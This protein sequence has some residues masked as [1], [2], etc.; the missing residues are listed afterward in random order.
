MLIPNWMSDATYVD[1]EIHNG[2]QTYKWEKTGNQANYLYETTETSPTNRTTI[3]VY[4]EPSD[5]QDFGSKSTVF[6]SGTFTLPSV[7]TVKNPTTWG[8]CKD[9]RDT[10]K[11]IRAEEA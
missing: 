7:C 9:I 6:P 11:K 5:F 4:Q 3:S 10:F 8:L 2:I 1:T